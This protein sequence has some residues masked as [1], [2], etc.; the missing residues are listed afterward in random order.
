MST[1]V[2]D[3]IQGKTTAGSVNV[4]GEGSNNT[5]LQQGLSKSWANI[6]GTGTPAVRDSFNVSTIV[7]RG[8]GLYTQ[9]FTSNMSNDDYAVGGSGMATHK[10]ADGRNRI[11]VGDPQST[12]DIHV[13]TFT[14]SGGAEDIEY[15]AA[16]AHGDL[17]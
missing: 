14:T 15:V 13:N 16:I 10:D 6:N 2:I 11:M 3:T 5:N 7:D 1:L 17:A 12:S 8:T 9:R 4:R